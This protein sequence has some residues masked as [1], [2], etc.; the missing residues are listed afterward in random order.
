M[1]SMVE[2]VNLAEKLRLQNAHI[3]PPLSIAD[4]GD[5]SH[6]FDAIVS[7]AADAVV[8]TAGVGSADRDSGGLFCPQ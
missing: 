1:E 6:D 5:V 2:S 4:R 7:G 8:P 3:T